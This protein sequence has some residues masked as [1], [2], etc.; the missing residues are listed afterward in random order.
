M[1][2]GRSVWLVAANS[3]RL[4]G[5][6]GRMPGLR[7]AG[8]ADRWAG[9][10]EWGPHG[11]RLG[12]EAVRR[13]LRIFRFGWGCGF[14]FF[15]LRRRNGFVDGFVGELAPEAFEAVEILH[16]AA[17]EAVGLGL[18]GRKSGCWGGGFGRGKLA[19]MPLG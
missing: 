18:G 8:N 17:V 2:G 19:A 1:A 12:R 4:C 10:A 11:R 6:N 15:E 14:S 7:R 16:G 9:G 13:R 5:A 3:T